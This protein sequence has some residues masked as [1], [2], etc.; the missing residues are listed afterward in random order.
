MSWSAFLYI[1]GGC[2]SLFLVTLYWFQD[3]LLYYP[4]MPSGAR[5]EFV[6]PNQFGLADVV[7]EVFFRTSDN[8]KIQAWII[9]SK[10]YRNA[11]TMLYF[12]G[13]A[14]NISH[15]LPNIAQIRSLLGCNVM[16]VSYRG[17]GKSEGIPTEKGLNLDA[18]AALEYLSSRDDIDTN[19][20][21]LF[22]RSLGAAV[23]LKLASE[24]EDKVRAVIVENTFTSILDMIDVVFP[25]L[26]YVK[27]LSSNEWNTVTAISK[28]KIPILFLAGMKDEL[29]PHAHMVQLYDAAKCSEGKEIYYFA[30]GHHMDTWNQPNYYQNIKTFIVKVFDK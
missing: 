29:V 9:L 22:G 25:L 30:Q 1:G 21:I 17:Y 28:I 2:V 24:N 4:N 23:A 16:I 14:G 11:P 5:T 15:R 6:S 7:K 10:D 12:H 26:K 27:F 18:K 13:N 20:I 8:V 19:K 3:Q